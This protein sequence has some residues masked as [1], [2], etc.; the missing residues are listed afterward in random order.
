MHITYAK[1]RAM[2]LLSTTSVS[3]GLVTKSSLVA[4]AV[5]MVIS[6][7]IAITQYARADKFDDQINAIQ[8]IVDGYQAQAAA[9]GAQAQ[10]LQTEL[11]SLTAQKAEIQSQVDLSQA[12]YDKLVNDIAVTEKQIAE[13]KD[14]LG[15]IIA[16]MYVDDTISPL[17]MLASSKNI[18]DYVDQQAYRS[19]VQD[20][21]STTIKQIDALKKQLEGQKKDV[22]RVL[23]DQQAQRDALAGKEAEQAKLL[24][25]TQG[26]ESAYQSLSKERSSQIEALKAQQAAEIAARAQQYGGG[27]TVA[28]DGSNGGYP[29]AWANSAQ[30]T[31]SDSWG[32]LNRECVSYVAFKVDQAF[33]NMPYWG[34]YGNANQWLGNARASGIPTGSTPKAGAV[35]VLSGGPYGHVA[36]VESVNANGTINISQY[37][38]GIRGSYSKW[39]NLNASYFDGYIY[40]GDS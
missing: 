24:S 2:K 25:D 13:N 40:F 28:T 23:A 16:D 33:G 30:D 7:P 39:Y 29:S 20:S 3:K 4:L 36:W 12:K 6:T 34:G 17:E 14:A 18:G 10:T 9:L 35:G 8:Q 31:I 26:Q 15:Q 22:E 32:M 5:V 21:L 19:S 11:A 1:I 27:Y 37:N 38:A